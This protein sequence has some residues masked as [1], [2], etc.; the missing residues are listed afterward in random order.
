MAE[1]QPKDVYCGCPNAVRGEATHIATDPSAGTDH[2]AYPSG[3]VAVVRSVTVPLDCVVFAKHAHP[4]T[5]ARISPDGTQIASGDEGGSVRI[6]D[7]DTLKEKAE[8]HVMGGAVRD[9]AFAADAK[10]LVVVGDSRGGYAKAVKVPSGSSSGA[11][12]GHT[13]R[14]IACHISSTKPALIA[15]GSEDMSVGL[16]KGPPVREMDIPKFLKQHTAFVNDVRFSPDAKFLAIASSD[17]TVTVVSVE[18]RDVVCTLAEHAASVTGVSWSQDSATLLTSGNDKTTKL[19]SIPSG[20]CMSTITYGKDVMDMQVGCA[21]T[22]VSSSIVSVA[23]RGDI[24]V[25][26]ASTDTPSLVM[27]GHAKQIVGLSVIGDKAYT[28]DYSGHMVAWDIGTGP[29]QSLFFNGKGPTTSVCAIAAN[30]EFVANVGQDGNIY[31]TP[32]TSL[33]YSKPVTVKGGGVD[34]AVPPSSGAP[35]AA[36]MINE[37]RLAAV[38]PGGGAVVAELVLE[39]GETG[40]S[41]AT[42]ADGFLI[43]IG[44]EIAGGSG[45]L[46]FLQISGST[47]VYKGD[48]IR[49]PSAPN[50]LAFSPDGYV[51]AVGEKSRRVKLYSPISRSSVIGGGIVHTARVDAIRF[52]PDGS[53]V[54]SGGM[55]GSVAVWPVDSEEE[56]LRLLSA[57]RN[58]VTGIGF[59]DASTLLTSGGDSCLRSWTI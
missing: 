22:P 1:I 29:S 50:R 34:I 39:R 43:A 25:T 45:E 7:R 2:I 53:R 10:F 57:H 24:S 15:T 51:I 23:L 33:T 6:W 56:P 54:A 18:T 3:R 48:A 9:I 31:V 38:A 17:R 55:D 49:M 59:C 58:G 8:M 35:F 30:D 26:K 13:K 44:V 27:R 28:A 14:V 52:S 21:I 47:F 40:C 46:R 41:I 42:T 19:W 5:C 37:T 16:F 20:S 4:V 32:T 12:Q 36:V 11:C